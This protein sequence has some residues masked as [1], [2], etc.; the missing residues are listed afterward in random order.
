MSKK[1][2]NLITFSV[3]MQDDYDLLDASI[4]SDNK[5]GFVQLRDNKLKIQGEYHLRLISECNQWRTIRL[6]VV[7][8]T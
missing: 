1:P 3:S 6:G 8:P 2:L 5:L 7:R 4:L